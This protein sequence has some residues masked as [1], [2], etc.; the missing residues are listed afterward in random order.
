M[1]ELG[2]HNN[3][4]L[5]REQLGTQIEREREREA[6]GRYLPNLSLDASYIWAEGGRTI[7]IPAGDLVNPAYEGLN[8]ILGENRYPANIPNVNE[9]FLPNNFH[10][11]KL[12][13]IQPILNSRIYYSHKAQLAQQSAQQ[14][15]QDSYENQLVKEIKVAYYQHLAAREQLVILTNTKDL[16]G[17]LL[18][19]NQRLVANDKATPEVIYAAQAEV[20]EIDSRL[21]GARKQVNTSRIFFNYL[22]SRDLEDSILIDSA[23]INTP[24]S[25]SPPLDGLHQRAL[26]D[27]REIAQVRYG[28]E[29]SELSVKLNR[30]YLL[31]EINA[32]GDIGYQGFD[33]TFNG[34]QEF[35]LIRLGLTWPIFQGFQNQSKIQQAVLGQQQRQSE[36]ADLQQRIA[37][38]V[39]QA[40]YELQE[41]QEM[42]QA[43]Q[44]E[45]QYAQET[46]RIVCKKYRQDQAILVELQEARTSYT[47]AQLNESVA[48]YDLKIKEATLAAATINFP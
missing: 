12:R 3:Q 25:L 19:V 13:L 48:R 42:L 43:R 32:V 17:E 2:L 30:S 38:E 36:L 6:R 21:A 4:Q 41:A 40:Y 34:N 20:S 44:A 1:F 18:R 23:A 31:P 14:A 7:N 8:Q 28:L 46:F 45:R 47:T 10:E 5:I 9:Q 27:R 22:L 16:L 39:S 24:V 37:L 15:Q 11:T 33:Y 29:A 35:W 26:A